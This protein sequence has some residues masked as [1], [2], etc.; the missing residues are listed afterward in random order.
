M[1][2]TKNKNASVMMTA[3]RQNP[4]TLDPRGPPEGHNLNIK[5]YSTIVIKIIKYY[6]ADTSA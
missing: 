3:F 2:V 5:M 4:S 1:E 6:S